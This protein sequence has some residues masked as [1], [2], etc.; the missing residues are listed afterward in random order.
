MSA[1]MTNLTIF[2]TDVV[3][4]DARRRRLYNN[5]T[6][7]GVKVLLIFYFLLSLFL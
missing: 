4:P 6:G 5:D 1:R 2:P 3:C 7:V